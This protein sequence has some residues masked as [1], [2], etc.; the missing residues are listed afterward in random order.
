MS[1]SSAPALDLSK[2]DE[3]GWFAQLIL[4]I[5]TAAPA[6]EPLLVGAM[7]RNLLLQYAHGVEIERITADVDFAL[8]VSDWA[9]FLSAREA[10]LACG[11]FEAHPTVLHKLRHARFGSIDL[12]PFGAVERPDGS[13]AWPPDGVE[14]MEVLGY[15]E[16]NAAAVTI[17][18]PQHQVIR[19]VSLPMLAVLKIFAWKARHAHT[20]GKDAYDLAV[21]LRNYLNAGNTERLYANFA[22]L[23]S[24]NFDFD[25]AGAWLLGRDA[26]E[27]MSRYGTRFGRLVELLDAVLIEESDP[28]GRLTLVS[29]LTQFNPAK[30]LDMLSALRTGLLGSEGPEP[31]CFHGK[32][33]S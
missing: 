20:Q 3:L 11:V 24:D 28:D 18:L 25:R 23:I 13:I 16:A 8:A 14:I 33:A 29:K 31:A 26:R 32:Q 5:R 15:S 27:Q 17:Q 19:A 22:H 30:G 4:D 21:I 9:A 7:A 2:E 12:V 6:L 1:E 10:L